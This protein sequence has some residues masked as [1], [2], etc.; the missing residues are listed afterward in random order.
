MTIRIKKDKTS[1]GLL[2]TVEKMAD[3]NL[4]VCFQCKKCDSGCPVSNLT[5]SPPSE[6]LRRLHLGAGNEL[7]TSDLV[8]MCVSCETCFVRCPMGI[9]IPSAIDALRAL[10][11]EQRTPTPEGNMLLFNRVFL[12]TVKI[13]GRTYDLG[14]IAAHKIGTKSYMKDADKFPLMLK[15]RKLAL[16]PPRGADRKMAKRVF[17]SVRREKENQK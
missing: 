12:K 13:F 16:L 9:D 2:R 1:Q 17:D 6:I 5:M 11:V 10:A 14:T 7:L 4:S 15:K 3:V 8:W